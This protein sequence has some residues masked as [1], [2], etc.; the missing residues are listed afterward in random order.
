MRR[1]WW[2]GGALGAAGLLAA[3]PAGAVDIVN[4]DSRAYDVRVVESPSS[5]RLSVAPYTTQMSVCW[6]CKITVQ[7]MG[8]IEVRPGQTVII[9]NGVA[10]AQD[11]VKPW[12]AT[13]TLREQLGLGA[14]PDNGINM[15]RT[16]TFDAGLPQR[17]NGGLAP[18]GQPQGGGNGGR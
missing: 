4:R 5:S 2:I 10:W 15:P 18:L 1:T 14:P 3:V 16:P 9:A 7:G 17:P 6:S 11:P 13:P 12:K 8:E